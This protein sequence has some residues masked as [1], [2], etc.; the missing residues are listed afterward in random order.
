M[1]RPRRGVERPWAFFGAIPRRAPAAGTGFGSARRPD[2]RPRNLVDSRLPVPEGRSWLVRRM[3]QVSED[4]GGL[5]KRPKAA[6]R[7]LRPTVPQLSALFGRS[8]THH[9]LV[10]RRSSLPSLMLRAAVP[11]NAGHRSDAGCRRT[12]PR[13][14][15]LGELEHDVATVTHDPGADLR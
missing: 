11:L 13:H 10:C 9:L 12:A 4:L 1:P 2:L 6:M 15:H 5:M 8:W 3:R 7:A 14:R